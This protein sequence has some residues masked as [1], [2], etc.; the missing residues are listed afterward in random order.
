MKITNLEELEKDK[1]IKLYNCGSQK[2][3]HEI[4]TKLN[5]VPVNIYKHRTTGKLVNVFVMTNELSE[6]LKQW[7]LNKPSKKKEAVTE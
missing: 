7:T 3:S 2:L 1:N 4:R 6:F 5:M